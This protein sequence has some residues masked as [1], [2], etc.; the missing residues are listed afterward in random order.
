MWRWL[1][2]VAVVLLVAA[3]VTFVAGSRLDAY[4]DAHR[5][6]FAARASAELGRTVQFGALEVS[7]R[8]GLSARMTDL[9]IAEDPRYG[10][11]DF[12]HANEARVELSLFPALLGT[13]HVRRIV[14]DGISAVL[15]RDPA[16]WNVGSLLARALP[17]RRDAEP[18]PANRVAG[19]AAPARLA[20]I[21]AL[22]IR[23][24]RVQ[25]IDRAQQPPRVFEVRELTATARELRRDSGEVTMAAAVFGS[26]SANVHI[27]GRLKPGDPPLADVAVQWAPVPISELQPYLPQLAER[28]VRAL[29]GGDL[30]LH[31]AI[32]D[33]SRSSSADAGLRDVALV[34]TALTVL[35]ELS[36]TLRFTEAAVELTGALAEVGGEASLSF[37]CRGAAPGDPAL[38]CDVA[39]DALPL[40]RFGLGRSRDE[41]RGVTARAQLRAPEATPAVHAELRIAA[42]Q[43]NGAP[44]RDLSAVARAQRGT[45]V[46]ETF[47]AHAFDGSVSGEA[48]CSVP[49]SGVSACD[50]HAVA[51]GVQVGPLVASVRPGEDHVSGRLD[52]DLHLSA[53]GR[54]ERSWRETLRGNG[55]VRVQ[56]GALKRV[57]LARV[58]LGQLDGAAVLFGGDDKTTVFE[59]LSAS[60]RI[61]AEEIRSPDVR[62]T[63]AD[64]TVDAH[65]SAAFS[66]RLAFDGVL[67][68][69]PAL[70]SSLLRSVP[71]LGRLSHS[72]GGAVAIPFQLRGTFENPRVLPDS[73]AIARSVGRGAASAIEALFKAADRSRG[74]G[75]KSL[76]DGLDRLLGR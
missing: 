45:C 64:F 3:G 20:T 32:H 19:I 60:I 52:A 12:I 54:D 31:G 46:I 1:V 51:A 69:S 2:G 7:L 24:G 37:H 67:T 11:G 74:K 61:E 68:T 27:S 57:N 58:L 62:M 8:G 76:R 43:V 13:Y 16:G 38:D 36:G 34:T 23:N 56:Q 49:D 4:L 15:I 5:E 6:A 30:R 65:G 14:L 35:R 59:Q 41:L 25:M 39:A 10:T 50:I 26:T 75:E 53:S 42:G 29:V 70:G 44:F 22:V 55:S 17:A 9:R 71:V 33:A 18:V 63:A 66:G 21:A 73:T 72:A 28:K 40:A 48:T 47:N